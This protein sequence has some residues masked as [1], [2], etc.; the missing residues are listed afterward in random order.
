MGRLNFRILKTML[1]QIALKIKTT[2]LQK[3]LGHTNLKRSL[4]L[5]CA[6]NLRV[7]KEIFKWA[8]Y[9]GQTPHQ[10]KPMD[11]EPAH[12]GSHPWEQQK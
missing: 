9:L 3:I 12:T 1:F 2:E 11:R 5:K 7:R 6:K 10:R 8:K 4:Y